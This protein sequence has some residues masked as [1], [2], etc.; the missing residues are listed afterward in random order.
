[1]EPVL[2]SPRYKFQYLPVG[3]HE[4]SKTCPVFRHPER[5]VTT[6]QDCRSLHSYFIQNEQRQAHRADN[7]PLHRPAHVR[8]WHNV[9]SSAW[10]GSKQEQRCTL[11]MTS[12]RHEEGRGFTPPL[13]RTKGGEL[14]AFLHRH[15]KNMT[16][17]LHHPHNQYLLTSP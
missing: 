6:P 11:D 15:H 17:D 10:W 12:G 8:H 16:I 4:N 7:E 3:V 5:G 13:P 1:M 2:A 14:C 9:N